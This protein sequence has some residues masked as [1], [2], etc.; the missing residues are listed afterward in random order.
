MRLEMR[1]FQMASLTSKK[2]H[3]V[4]ILINA[5]YRCAHECMHLDIHIQVCMN[6][7]MSACTTHT[8]SLTNGC[9]S[10]CRDGRASAK[11][12]YSSNN[13][14]MKLMASWGELKPSDSC[15]NKRTL[16]SRRYS[17]ASVSS[18]WKNYTQTKKTYL[19]DYINAIVTTRRIKWL[20]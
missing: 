5:F 12:K 19:Y 3:A 18:L 13:I 8:L 20:V 2:K 1:Q 7:S 11:V 6:T 15:S 16:T 14:S 10:W 9:N 17:L 4:A